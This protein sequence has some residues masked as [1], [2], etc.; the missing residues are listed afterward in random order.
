MIKRR[1]DEPAAVATGAVTPPVLCRMGRPSHRRM[2][3]R[4]VWCQPDTVLDARDYAV[5]PCGRRGVCTASCQVRRMSTRPIAQESTLAK[6]TRRKPVPA[7]IKGSA[8]NTT[9]PSAR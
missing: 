4:R 6:G 7:K 5:R 9:F 2:S 3:S 8:P 1:G